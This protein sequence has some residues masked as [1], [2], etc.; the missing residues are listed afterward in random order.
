MTGTRTCD[1]VVVGGG[2]MGSSVAYHLLKTDPGLDV[3]VVE[4]DPSY[5]QA[6]SALSAGNAR[7]QFSLRENIEISL[8]ALEVFGRFDEAMSV[9]DERPDIRFRQEGNLFLH[10]PTGSDAA[11]S[12]LALQKRFGGEVELWSP[13]E[14][15][16]MRCSWATRPRRSLWERS[17]SLQRSRRSSLA[18]AERR[19]CNW[20][21]VSI[22]GLSPSSIAPVP[23]PDGWPRPRVSSFPSSP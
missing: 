11:L 9:E 18:A 4:R 16:V 22:S 23:G 19:A 2:V 3:V 6:S 15:R 13:E 14:I 5:S 10:E 17:S 12:A 7:I 20:S 1:V 21:R 8:H